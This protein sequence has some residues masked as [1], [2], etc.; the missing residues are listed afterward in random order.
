MQGGDPVGGGSDRLP[1]R[2]GDRHPDGEAGVDP[3]LAQAAD[4]GQEPLGAAGRVR[5]DQDRGAVAVSV[6]D[7]LQGLVQ[8]GDVVGGRVRTGP[9]RP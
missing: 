2:F 7:L 9:P 3:V 4:V 5:P 8:D 1:D 6:R